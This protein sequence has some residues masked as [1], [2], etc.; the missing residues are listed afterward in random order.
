[1]N[2]WNPHTLIYYNPILLNWQGND[3]WSSNTF[4]CTNCQLTWCITGVMHTN[5]N[6]LCLGDLLRT[7]GSI[8]FMIKNFLLCPETTASMCSL[9]K[10]QKTLLQQ[11]QAVSVIPWAPESLI[12]FFDA[13]VSSCELIHLTQVSFLLLLPIHVCCGWGL[14]YNQFVGSFIYYGLFVYVLQLSHAHMNYY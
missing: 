8:Y 12:L 10:W 6:K 4:K 14:I 2:F 11:F 3:C 9:K 1:M 7:V 5:A 13:S